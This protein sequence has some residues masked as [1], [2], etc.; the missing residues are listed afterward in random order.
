MPIRVLGLL[1][2]LSYISSTTP[3]TSE[4]LI[5]SPRRAFRKTRDITFSD[6]CAMAFA[7]PN[8]CAPGIMTAG[9]D[10]VSTAKLP[11]MSEPREIPVRFGPAGRVC[12]A[13]WRVSDSSSAGT[14][15]RVISMKTPSTE[16]FRSWFRC[17]S[18][19]STKRR[20]QKGCLSQLPSSRS[21]NIPNSTA[22]VS[23]RCNISPT[24]ASQ[25]PNRREEAVS[26]QLRISA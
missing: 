23:I 1:A 4:I 15:P 2:T 8:S 11:A 7:R 9:L 26:R 5:F 6:R 25:M 19:V 21:M 16:L 24:S 10:G 12:S 18:S 22:S 3:S 14:L 20:R 17:F 13:G